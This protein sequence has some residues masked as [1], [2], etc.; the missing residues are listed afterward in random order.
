MNICISNCLF[1]AT[2][3]ASVASFDRE[4]S[5]ACS[6]TLRVYS[7]IQIPFSSEASGTSSRVVGL[8]LRAR[9]G[10]RCR[11]RC[12]RAS[13]VVAC[14]LS[15]RPQPL[16][17]V[18][19]LEVPEDSAKTPTAPKVAI[20]PTLWKQCTGCCQAMAHPVTMDHMVGRVP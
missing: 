12:T 11:P 10:T 13:T 6:W 7:P 9:S 14:G 16:R 2:T 20:I 17:Q 4:R 19:L 18:S 1:V 8:S 3:K 5:A 15:L